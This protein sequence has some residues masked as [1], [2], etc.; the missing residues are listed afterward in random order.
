MAKISDKE[1]AL[2]R[3]Y[4]GAMLALAET[5]GQG[6]SLLEELTDLVALLDKDQALNRF[7]C[8]PDVDPEIRK[9]TMEKV[10]RGRASDLLVDSLQVLNRKGRLLIL[11]AIAETYRLAH[12]DLR[13][14]I[15]VTV[16][17]ASPLTDEL[18]EKV[19]QV[20]MRY[21]NKEAELI[22]EIDESLIGGIVM[23]VGDEKFD[24]SVASRLSKL[25]SLLA[26]RASQEIHGGKKYVLDASA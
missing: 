6:D 3:V 24:A 13:G 26:E 7:F 21:A 14:R 9:G 10:F 25:G 5:Q 1:I 15:D 19:R 23:Q 20:A 12:E 11:R 18:R 16:R 17:S 2:A 22:E 8:S 4:S